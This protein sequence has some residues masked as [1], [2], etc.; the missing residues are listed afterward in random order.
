MVDRAGTP[1][2]APESGLV[3]EAKRSTAKGGGYGFYVKL[4]GKGREHILAHMIAG[5]LRVKKG[6]RI[7]QGQV[8]GL[9]GTTGA[10]TGVHLHWEIRIKG[11]F[12]DPIKVI[13]SIR[14][15]K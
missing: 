8:V 1:I 11:Q 15:E 3:L 4:R 7:E 9:M 14:S 12:V 5:S 13:K 10:S 2:V 6:Q